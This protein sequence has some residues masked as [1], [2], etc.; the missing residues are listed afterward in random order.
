MLILSG[1][2]LI[3]GAISSEIATPIKS[4]FTYTASSHAELLER[5]KVFTQE[6]SSTPTR[7]VWGT[8]APST[9]PKINFEAQPYFYG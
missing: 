9:L 8:K 3:S 4:V 7:L 1:P 6:K 5:N 2:L